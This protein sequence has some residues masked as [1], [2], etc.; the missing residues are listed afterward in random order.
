MTFLFV[1][2]VAVLL[3]MGGLA[4]GIKNKG[5]DWGFLLANAV[6]GWARIY[7]RRFHHINP[8]NLSIPSDRGSIVVSNHISGLDP[9]LLIAACDRP[10]RF[11]IAKEEYERFGLTWLFKRAGCIP[12]DRD[13]RV[14]GAFR[15]AIRQLELGEVVALFPHGR[16]HLD[17][18]K[19]T[20]LKPGLRKLVTKVP[21]TVFPLRLEGVRA[22]GSVFT[23]L[24]LRADINIQQFPS[25]D[26]QAFEDKCIDD[27]LGELLLGRTDS[28]EKK[29]TTPHL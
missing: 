19:R 29:S 6:D 18:E 13:G 12:V 16:I 21:C 2:S 15:E 7:C 5:A 14:D 3:F 9:L 22:Q 11:L 20:K 25:I 26:S 28:L 10:L 1:A 4:I 24:L 23:S 17:D 27:R 8:I